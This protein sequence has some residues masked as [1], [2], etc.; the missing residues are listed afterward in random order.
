[1]RISSDES[2]SQREV[3]D[4]WRK[5]HLPA[6]GIDTGLSAIDHRSTILPMIAGQNGIRKLEDL[7][8]R[9]QTIDLLRESAR[10]NNMNIAGLVF[11]QPCNA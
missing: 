3:N 6:T 7:L 11:I 8:I 1:L 10:K 9:R 2:V 5:T 4:I